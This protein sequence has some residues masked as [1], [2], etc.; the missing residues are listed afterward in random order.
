MKILVFS[1]HAADFCS[2]AGGT[3]AKYA[4]AGAQV[5]VV[6]LTF[7]ERSESGGLYAEGARPPLDEVRAIRRG[8]AERAAAILGVTISF[9]NWGDL[10]LEP[11][12]ERTRA[13]SEEIRSMRPDAILTHHGPDPCSVD[14]DVSWRL[15][16][17]ARQLAAT[18]G[19]ESPLPHVGPIPLFLFEATLPLTE[20]EGFVPDLYVDITDVWE[21]KV[22]ALRE[23][24]QAQSFLVPWYT[25]AA[26][27][28]GRQAATI[29]GRKEILY[30]EAFERML[31]WVGTELPL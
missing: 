13:L 4:R 15:V 19:L 16:R 7:G 10:S 25:D 3:L 27:L 8:D 23:F 24:V 11:A 2:R 5:R 30:A 29:S 17:R 9:L 20:A 1:A 18:V 26:R 21:Q 12:V 6:S 28:R 31:P 22:E 14:H